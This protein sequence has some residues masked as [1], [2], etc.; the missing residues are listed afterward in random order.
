MITLEAK[1]R[2]PTENL[3]KLRTEGMVPAVFYGAGKQT[4]MI[5]VSLI[6]FTRVF[7]EAGE[8]TTVNL[9]TPEG[10]VST[11][12][13][14]V[15]HHPVNG[16]PFHIDFL[17]VDIHKPVEVH[18][19]LEFVGV[20]PAVKGNIGT[21]VK[22][23]HEVEIKALPN[24][25]PHGIEV[26]ISVLENADSQIHASDLKLPKGVTLVTE[27][28]EVVASISVAQEETEEAAPVDLASIEVEKKGKKEEETEA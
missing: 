23:L 10:T 6:D 15:Q 19:P 4:T 27:A 16:M 2:Q 8:S 7:R 12:V 3:E 14:E 5:S 1:L 9:K 24:D 25:L 20:A 13:H 17:V 26:D 18:V 21:L 11:L 22:V 28:E